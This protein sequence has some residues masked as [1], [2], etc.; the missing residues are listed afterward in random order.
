MASDPAQH[1][2]REV[3]ITLPGADV[4]SRTR[5]ALIKTSWNA[6]L[7]NALSNL[8][9]AAL[10]HYGVAEANI[11]EETVPGAFE[12]PLAAKMIAQAGSSDAIIGFGVLL[13]GETFHF[14]YISSSTAHGM[15]DVQV[16]TGVPTIYGVLN[17]M[18]NEQA[19]SRCSPQ[20]QLPYSLA[21]SAIQMAALRFKYV[22]KIIQRNREKEENG[23]DD[24]GDE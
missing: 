17:C 4:I 14:E 2:L 6:A 1:Y 15:M 18:N 7:V 23:E 12:L 21:S 11:L 10:I 16:R 13:K 5:I 3:Q 8:T 22:P 20:S 9:K 24:G 19:Q